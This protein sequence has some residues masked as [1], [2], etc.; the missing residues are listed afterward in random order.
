MRIELGV[1]LTLKQISDMCGGKSMIGDDPIIRHISTDSRTL[2]PDD[3]FISLYGSRFNGDDFILAAKKIGAY[4]L[5]SR[6]NDCDIF[7]ENTRDALLHLAHS[8]KESLPY[9]LY[10]IAITGSVGKTTTKEFLKLLLSGKYPTHASR[11]NHNNEIGMP[12]S[13]LEAK[14]D[15]K[16]LIMEMGMNSLGEISRLSKCLE[17]SIAVITNIGTAHIGKLGSR[18]AIARAKLEVTDGMKN[19]ILLYPKDEELIVYQGRKKT[20]SKTN[21]NADYF[22]KRTADDQIEIQSQGKVI[23]SSRFDLWEDYHLDCLVSAV[24]AAI[25]AEVCPQDISERISYISRLN[26]R[27]KVI[28]TSKYI[29]YSDCYNA[30]LESM[31]AVISAFSKSNI[32]GKK[33]L[34]LGDIL[35]LGD[36]RRD[37]HMSIGKAIN[38]ETV[39]NLF[40]FGNHSY[41]IGLG[42]IKNNFPMERI[43]TVTNESTP[44]AI[45]SL[46]S[47]HC[48]EGEHILM[49]ASRGIMLERVLNYFL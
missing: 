49:K 47:L 48:D 8:Y 34:L 40:L 11:E 5:S 30:S 1:P 44:Q 42:A 13:I 21:P 37:I 12:M 18:N 19:G 45:A 6:K 15:T 41:E 36:H 4:V 38:R 16:A 25:E 29:F 46:I 2:Y 24:G 23:C 7:H 10:N 35:E 17:P 32:Q 31:L 3:L 22:I 9:L 33:S 28:S 43:F 14:Q 20:F 27:Q 39:N 26:T